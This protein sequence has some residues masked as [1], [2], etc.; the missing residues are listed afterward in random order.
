MFTKSM[1]VSRLFQYIPELRIIQS[2]PSPKAEPFKLWFAQVGEVAGIA[3]EALEQ[4]T[5]AAVISP[6][7][8]P[9]LNQVFKG[10]IESAAEIV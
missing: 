9:R 5:G 4:R 2:I 8:A 7:G 10:M 6:E 1:N 3:R